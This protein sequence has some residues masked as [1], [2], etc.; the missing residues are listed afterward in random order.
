MAS[1]EKCWGKAFRRSMETGKCQA[2][3]YHE[4]LK[5]VDETGIICTP[6]ERAGQFWDEE[7]QLDTRSIKK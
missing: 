5:E 3:C 1:C 4:I 6:K 2:E 7:K